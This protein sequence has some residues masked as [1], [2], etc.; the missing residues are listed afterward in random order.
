MDILI[1]DYAVKDYET[2]VIPKKCELCGEYIS[3]KV[4]DV[5]YEV[6][7]KKF[8]WITGKQRWKKVAVSIFVCETCQDEILKRY[9]R[10][11]NAETSEKDT[12][13]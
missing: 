3:N 13:K 8:V 1:D 5:I 6:E 10:R 4:L 9:E 7:L 11:K 12:G 2:K